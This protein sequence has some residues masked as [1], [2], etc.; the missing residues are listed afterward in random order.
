MPAPLPAEHPTS[1]PTPRWSGVADAF[2]DLGEPLTSFGRLAIAEDQARA[3]EQSAVFRGDLAA[4]R[5][6]ADEREAIQAD[7]EALLERHVRSFLTSLRWAVE[8]NPVA[9]ASILAPILDPIR[10]EVAGIIDAIL[11]RVESLEG[12]R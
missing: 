9:V 8:R 4:A 6:A 11:D 7:V 10:D 2:Q 3:R 5:V 1:P 12:R